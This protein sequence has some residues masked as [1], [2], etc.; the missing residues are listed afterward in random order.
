MNTESPATQYPELTKIFYST[1]EVGELF[2]FAENTVRGWCAAGRLRARNTGN[3]YMIPRHAILEFLEGTD[4]P[5]AHPDN[6]G[7]RSA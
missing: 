3:R 4:E 6:Q 1:R 7:R 2:G 5:I